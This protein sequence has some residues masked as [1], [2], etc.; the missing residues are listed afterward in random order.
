[1]ALQ[2]QTGSIV[3]PPKNLVPALGMAAGVSWI[4]SLMLAPLITVFGPGSAET[5]WLWST[6]RLL[7]VLGSAV[8]LSAIA[9]W[10]SAARPAVRLLRWLA[11]TGA[12]SVLVSARPILDLVVG[13]WDDVGYVVD[14]STTRGEL[15]AR[16]GAAPTPTI[17][18]R[19]TWRGQSHGDLSLR[20]V[21]L[22]A[23]RAERALLG[24]PSRSG[25]LVALRY[26][27]IL[28]TLDCGRQ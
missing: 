22:Q 7:W 10:E 18:G 27:H 20:P 15:H 4:S 8:A 25:R 24:C 11:V 6:V 3:M 16:V 19:F 14:A 23:S 28:I 13:P 5:W 9:A 12:L 26:Q 1:M 2:K 21:G 17:N